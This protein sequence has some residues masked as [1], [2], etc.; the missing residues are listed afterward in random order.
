MYADSKGM[1]AWIMPGY[2]YR[3]DP[4]GLPLALLYAYEQ[5]V[6]GLAYRYTLYSTHNSPFNVLAKRLDE[7]KLELE[8][9]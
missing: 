3:P 4:S 1:R 8:D 6:E 7:D 5:I 9:H 2:L